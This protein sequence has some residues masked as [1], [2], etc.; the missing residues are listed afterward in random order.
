MS[1]VSLRLSYATGCYLPP[2]SGCVRIAATAE[3]LALSRQDNTA[4]R[5]KRAQYRGL[6][7]G[8][9]QCVEARLCGS[10]PREEPLRAP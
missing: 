7:E 3:L 1:A 9:L 8:L 5:V 10:D 6:G 2:S 4:G